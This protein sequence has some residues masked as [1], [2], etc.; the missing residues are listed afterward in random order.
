MW[1]KK[2]LLTIE[3]QLLITLW[4]NDNIWS[5]M[6]HSLREDQGLLTTGSSGPTGHLRRFLEPGGKN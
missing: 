6:I 3:E 4:F 5:R 1:S 2:G